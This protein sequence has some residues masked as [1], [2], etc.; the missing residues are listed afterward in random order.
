MLALLVYLCFWTMPLTKPLKLI[1]IV[2]YGSLFQIMIHNQ[3]V[4]AFISLIMIFSPLFWSLFQISIVIIVSLESD[5]VHR[6]SNIGILIRYPAR[7]V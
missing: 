6:G 1:T 2:D 3:G 5:Y 4:L 7:S